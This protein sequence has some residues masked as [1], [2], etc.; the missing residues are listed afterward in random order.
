MDDLVISPR[1]HHLRDAM[2]V[3]MTLLLG[4]ET[5]LLIDAGYGISNVALDVGRLAGQTPRLLLTHGHHDHALGARFFPEV[6]LHEKDEQVYHVYTRD[7]WKSRV[8]G[9]ARDKGLEAVDDFSTPLPGCRSFRE[10]PDNLGSMPV[11]Y[12]ESPGHTPG[13]LMIYLPEESILITGD[14]WNPTTWCF[15]PEAE[16][17]QTLR[18]SLMRAIELPFRH[19]LCSHDH[20]LHARSD[21]EHFLACTTP[22][23]L[24]RAEPSPQGASVNRPTV[25]LATPG[26][27]HIVFDPEKRQEAD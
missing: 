4:D 26:G 20:A 18:L 17:I 8:R 10:L 9:Q 11:V 23:W 1:V 14:D 25:E 13:S 2:G 21:I 12:L 24:D 7:P 16:S 3:C 22:E 6:Y 5:S 27:Q 19:V 15:F